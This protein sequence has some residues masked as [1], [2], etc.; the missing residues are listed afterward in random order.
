MPSAGSPD[1]ISSVTF[2]IILGKY[3]NS[4]IAITTDPFSFH[5][6]SLTA[7][8]RVIT[9]HSGVFPM[10]GLLPY[11][12]IKEALN[13]GLLNISDFEPSNLEACSYDLRIGTIFQDGQIINKDHHRNS[14]QFLT[15]S[16][17]IIFDLAGEDVKKLIIY[18]ILDKFLSQLLIL[19]R[20]RSPFS[21]TNMLL[22]R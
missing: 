15:S 2:G 12:K 8:E 21:K 3:R 14:E 1:S 10:P 13:D 11:Q 19:N 4:I 16:P 7:H 17:A 18:Q 20:G 6:L 5:P 9:H 22:V